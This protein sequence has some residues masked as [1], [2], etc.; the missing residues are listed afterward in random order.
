MTNLLL[1]KDCGSQQNSLVAERCPDCF[2]KYDEQ[3]WFKTSKPLPDGDYGWRTKRGQ[4]VKYLFMVVDG[5][6]YHGGRVRPWED[7]LGGEWCRIVWPD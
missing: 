4:S 6:L 3:D 2:K 7:Y 5:I 1:C